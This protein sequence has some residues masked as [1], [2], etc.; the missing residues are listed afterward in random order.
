IWDSVVSYTGPN[1][2][3]LAGYINADGLFFETGDQADGLT[4][5]MGQ[6]GDPIGAAVPA[7]YDPNTGHTFSYSDDGTDTTCAAQTPNSPAYHLLASIGFDI[8]GG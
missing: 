8:P 6:H 1:P 2:N 3:L 7:L 4:M 5:T